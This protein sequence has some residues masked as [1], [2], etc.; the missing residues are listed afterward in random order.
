MN[1]TLPTRAQLDVLPGAVLVEFGAAYCGHCQRAE[2]LIAAA[3]RPH[4]ARIR[5]IRIEDGPGKRLG[6]TFGVK[7]W[8]TLIVL[9]DG[10]EI[11]RRVRPLSAQDIAQALAELDTAP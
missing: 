5:H 8:P 9:R 3:L 4:G 10:Q 11:A 7:L 6:R 2:P 1:E